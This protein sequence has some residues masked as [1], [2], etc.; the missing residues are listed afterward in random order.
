MSRLET[1]ITS[2]PWASV[3]IALGIGYGLAMRPKSSFARALI[4]TAVGTTFAVLRELASDRVAA[5]VKSRAHV[6]S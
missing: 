5:Y 4:S 6:T 3:A 1:T 2:H